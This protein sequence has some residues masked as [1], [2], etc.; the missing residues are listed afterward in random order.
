MPG[1]LTDATNNKVLDLLFGSSAF[2]PPATLY[3]GLAINHANKLGVA[4]EPG[5]SGYAR[6]ALPNT[7]MSFSTAVCGTKSN[8]V[9]VTFP[10]PTAD[11]GTVQSLFLSDSPRGGT[12]LAMADLASARTITAGSAAAK[13]AVGSL[14]FS[15][16]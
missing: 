13:V 7:S 6:V 11:W 12:V 4:Y 14:L 8:A 5:G 10:A 15:H 3:V 9:A 1:F 16:A 2:M